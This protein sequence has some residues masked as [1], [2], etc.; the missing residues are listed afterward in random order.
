MFSIEVRLRSKVG[1]LPG[2]V[3]M[4]RQRYSSVVH[5]VHVDK[6]DAYVRK[7]EKVKYRRPVAG[8]GTNLGPAHVEPQK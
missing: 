1:C 8:A 5:V 6:S 3:W 2:Q 7:G 4:A